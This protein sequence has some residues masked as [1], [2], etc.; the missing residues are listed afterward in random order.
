[1]LGNGL[2]DDCDGLTD[3]IRRDFTDGRFT[4]GWAQWDYGVSW[5]P[6][7]DVSRLGVLVGF[8]NW[9][10][11]KDDVPW[12]SGS[13]H[14][15][16][17]VSRLD[18]GISCL[19]TVDSS[20]QAPYTYPTPLGLGYNE[21]EVSRTKL[22]DPPYDLTQVQI[23][24][25]GSLGYAEI[26]WVTI[27]NGSYEWPPN[28]D[29][30]VVYEDAALPGGGQAT[31]VVRR[32][33]AGECWAASDLGGLAWSSDC[34]TWDTR[35]G[36]WDDLLD[37]ASLGVWDVHAPS[38]PPGSQEVFAVAG[39]GAQI[40]GTYEIEGALLHT[41]DGGM[42]WQQIPS[43]DP[44][45]VFG[46]VDHC[47]AEGIESA[48][49]RRGGDL[50]EPWQAPNGE[51]QLF[52]ANHE[53]GYRDVYVL[54][55]GS[56]PFGRVFHDPVLGVDLFQLDEF[57]GALEVV[58][59]P[60]DS[61]S[62]FIGFKTRGVY[63]CDLPST[64]ILQTDTI[65]CV[66]IT[67]PTPLDVRDLR[68]LT[69]LDALLVVDGGRRY[70]AAA[71]TC[72][73]DEGD[74][75]AWQVYAPSTTGPWSL[76]DP[77]TDTSYDCD[78]DP[79][80]PRNRPAWEQ[81]YDY[82]C[83]VHHGTGRLRSVADLDQFGA[84]EL[85]GF[86]VSDDEDRVLVFFDASPSTP[87]TR[88]RVYF[89]DMPTTLGPGDP[90][91]WSPLQD[92]YSGESW[93]NDADP[94][95]PLTNRG[96]RNLAADGQGT[97]LDDQNVLD[98]WFPALPTSGVFVD[99]EAGS[100]LLVASGYG[101]YRVPH[102]DPG[103]GTPGWDSA[104]GIT[105]PDLDSVPCV[106]GLAPPATLG[107][108]LANH[109]FGLTVAKSA[110]FCA[111]CDDPT[112]R[113]ADGWGVA[114]VSDLGVAHFYGP[115]TGAWPRPEANV[116]CHF[117]AWTA[118][119]FSVSGVDL[120]DGT[121]ASW[122]AV[123]PQSIDPAAGVT[124]QALFRRDRDGYWCYE[125]TGASLSARATVLDGS[126]QLLCRWVGGGAGY[127]SSPVSAAYEW[128]PCHDDPTPLLPG[129]QLTDHGVPRWVSTSSESLSVAAFGATWDGSSVAA[130]GH[131]GL[132]LLHTDTAVTPEQTTIDFIPSIED[133]GGDA[134]GA[135]VGGAS[136]VTQDALFERRPRVVVDANASSYTDA[137]DYSLRLYLTFQGFGTA[138]P[139]LDVPNC[140]VWEVVDSLSP[141][142]A[143]STTWTSMDLTAGGA[144]PLDFDMVQ[145]VQVA[146]WAW[147]TAFVFGGAEGRGGGI[148]ALPAASDP[149]PGDDPP[150]LVMSPARWDF[151]VSHV[152][153][154]PHLADLL[155]V[156]AKHE[157]SQSFSSRP[158]LL[159]V[160]L[161]YDV[162]V[163]DWVWV[164]GRDRS[165]SLVNPV[166]EFVEWAAY[167]DH[168]TEFY[169][170]SNGSALVMGGVWW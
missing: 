52:I 97:W 1:M 143:R 140:R 94:F 27:A 21:I 4:L 113:Y 3:A 145:G 70:D 158:G 167:D 87:V 35:N 126:G 15:G 105:A 66:D 28:T 50:L 114:A 138:D 77:S 155:L 122:M 121:A 13:P 40:S 156:G 43:H 45:G 107:E 78:G 162:R 161:R 129:E 108:D 42:D 36:Q 48:P 124:G 5:G 74:V 32:G 31:T 132:A 53:A 120:G 131:G 104:Y 24:C 83:H 26:D 147:D 102:E 75:L 154:H 160:N 130:D 25:Y 6:Q 16:I 30:G 153:P 169:A 106:F 164:T 88:P 98:G 65:D 92:F 96:Q 117:D 112:G 71:G 89:A 2:D 93:T 116:D 11:V 82:R 157:W 123:G 111:E 81:N 41:T 166:I 17:E 14:F 8:D 63:R 23:D 76:D 51:E 60:D 168:T 80:D 58:A 46:V 135:C 73:L 62:L 90:V 54:D 91:D 115:E 44:L 150:V 10:R 139:T 85:T 101:V 159:L 170:A 19:L 84:G 49:S 152:D 137:T 34:E 133:S 103:T 134:R 141:G 151:I 128:P 95:D 100:D 69:T 37:H 38:E 72:D 109:Q 79:A 146:D 29:H 125:S 118:G 59:W 165:D 163:L 110:F 12:Q 47:V 144:C 86:A 56:T 148:C 18:S 149:D 61:S 7:G 22:G 127:Y 119:G 67:G 57:V 33:P 9:M 20:L 68:Y 99:G 142:T 39:R 136:G 64:R 55:P